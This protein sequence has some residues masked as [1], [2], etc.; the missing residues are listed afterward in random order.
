[1]KNTKIVAISFFGLMFLMMALLTIGCVSSI[2]SL[3]FAIGPTI[4]ALI[5]SAVFAS[6]TWC[7]IDSFKRGYKEF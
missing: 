1:M 2:F 7:I 4:C 3:N 6:F 5:M